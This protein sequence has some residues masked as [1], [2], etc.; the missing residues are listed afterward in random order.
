MSRRHRSQCAQVVPLARRRRSPPT[1]VERFAGGRRRSPA[2]A[3][4]AV[5]GSGGAA[6]GVGVGGAA[7]GVRGAGKWG[8]NVAHGVGGAGHRVAGAAHEV[9]WE[10]P[11]GL[12]ERAV[13][14]LSQDRAPRY[15]RRC[16]VTVPERVPGNLTACRSI[17]APGSG[18]IRSKAPVRCRTQSVVQGIDLLRLK[19]PRPPL[20]SADLMHLRCVASGA[21]RQI[22]KEGLRAAPRKLVA[23]DAMPAVAA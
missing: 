13:R 2:G 16:S 5:H 4:A 21:V 14:F 11:E 9:G 12:V 22:L 6:Q 8:G 18:H 10:P 1:A 23:C 19:R 7:H 3:G 20:A 17:V 15:T